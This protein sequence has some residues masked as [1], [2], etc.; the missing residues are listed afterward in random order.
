MLIHEVQS[1]P[2]TGAHT[3]VDFYAITQGQKVHTHIA[4]HFIGDAPAKKDG[5]IIE[6][7]MKEVEVKC[8]PKDLVDHFEVDLSSL[9]AEGDVIRVSDL[10]VDAK[11]YDILAH[12]EEVIATASLP[13]SAVAEEQETTEAAPEVK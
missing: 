8:L 5:A 10:S 9:K 1:H 12:A 2:V 4:L 13:R 6:E 7:Y 11:K 3:H